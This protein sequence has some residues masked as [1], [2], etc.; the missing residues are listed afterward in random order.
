M[1]V[2]LPATSARRQ[3]KFAENQSIVDGHVRIRIANIRPHNPACTV[4]HTAGYMA[5]CPCDEIPAV[6]PSRAQDERQCQASM[7]TPDLCKRRWANGAASVTAG[8]MTS[9][10]AT[11]RNG[12]HKRELALIA[13]TMAIRRLYSARHNFQCEQRTSTRQD[14]TNNNSGRLF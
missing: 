13:A 1:H 2:P 11:V 14:S 5:R 12:L 10:T 6:V 7:S 9:D 4:L 8:L 3:H